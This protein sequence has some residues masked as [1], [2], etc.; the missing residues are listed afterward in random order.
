MSGEP[1][2]HSSEF[3]VDEYYRSCKKDFANEINA[4]T[5]AY[6]KEKMVPHLLR[7]YSRARPVLR[8]ME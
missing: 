6:G 5:S 1:D 2:V 7:A 8:K 4:M 3:S